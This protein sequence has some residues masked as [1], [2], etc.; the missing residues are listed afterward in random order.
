MKKK[1]GTTNTRI[2]NYNQRKQQTAISKPS[3]VQYITVYDESRRGPGGMYTQCI[4]SPILGI[5]AFGVLSLVD[6]VP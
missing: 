1:R 3:E 2:V 6:L 4:L 5:Q